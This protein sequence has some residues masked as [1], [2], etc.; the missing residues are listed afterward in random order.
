MS[1]LLIVI[2]SST[3]F[4]AQ[5]ADVSSVTSRHLHALIKRQHAVV[6]CDGCSSS[7][8]HLPLVK[9]LI[10]SPS[11]SGPLAPSPERMSKSSRGVYSLYDI[12]MIGPVSL[13]I[14]KKTMHYDALWRLLIVSQ[15]YSRP[16]V[17]APRHHK[18]GC[19]YIG[20]KKTNP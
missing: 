16:A 12:F 3:L 8:L 6:L 4:Y 7:V 13:S 2:V 20:E 1:W 18:V 14:L 5:T 9:K 15:A 10:N 19:F 17:Y 11:P